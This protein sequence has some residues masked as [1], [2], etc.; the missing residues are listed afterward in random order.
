MTGHARLI[1]IVTILVGSFL[2]FLVQPL[3]ARMALPLLGGAP[4]V[5]NSAMLV[6]QALL[7]GGYA[8]AHAL[9]RLSLRRQAV[10]HLG[11][12]ALAGLTLP[13]ALADLPSPAPGW[14][15]VWVPALFLATVGPV[16]FVVSAQAPLMQRWFAADDGAGDPY[17][18]YSASNIGSFAGLVSYPF[19][20]E[21]YL[22]IAGQTRLWATGY[23]VLVVLVVLAVSARWNSAST[24]K[25]AA[26]AEEEVAAGGAASPGAGRIL[27]W[28]ALAAV[29]SGLMLST[30]THLTTDIV[31]M[32]LLWVVP[33]G[34]YLLSFSFAF[35][36]RSEFA[37]A[38]ARLAPLALLLAGSI[39]M[40]SGGHASLGLL[41]GSLALLLILATALHRRLYELRPDASRL[42]LFYLVMSAGGALGGLFTALI[43]PIAFDWVWEHPLLLL[44]AAALLPLPTLVGWRAK[45]RVSPKAGLAAILAL[46]AALA[47]AM[48]FAS[49]S[50]NHPVLIATTFGLAL[51]GVLALPSRWA[52]LAIFAALL[53]A[54]GG[55]QTIDTSLAGVRER[56]YFGIYTRDDDPTAQTRS[57]L[58]GTTVHGLQFTDPQQRRAPTTYYGP[59]SGVGLALTS[60]PA[61]GSPLRI[62]AV[63]LGTGTLA[64]YA[65][66]GQAWT[67]FEIDPVVA[68]YS[69]DGTF[70]FIS[71]CT[72]DADILIGD[73]RLVLEKVPAGAFDVLV[74]DAFSSDSIPLHLVTRE[75]LDI[76]SRTL[77]DDGLLLFH[78]SNRFIDLRPALAAHAAERGWPAMVRLDAGSPARSVNGSIWV[79]MARD[80]ARLDAVAA[81][82]PDSPW[83][84]LPAPAGKVWTD[85]HATILPYI[86][87]ERMA[88][89]M[90][91]SP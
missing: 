86:M 55:W 49:A 65:R 30:T 3:V 41:F 59:R 15:A 29:P 82:H 14:E 81:A 69:R 75:A 11:L 2:L 70:S 39:A 45:G 26:I 18:L 34:L 56:S 47:A 90:P 85:D 58:H 24:G 25:G 53:V 51:C 52:L 77:A 76:Y 36:D 87:W 73:A 31:A 1:F 64:C 63:G 48:Y 61:G 16:F 6:Y 19:L 88:G 67:F 10:V 79:V 9:S 28:L 91:S 78:I 32:P 50:E 8:Y 12:L 54:R 33:L 13:I 20:L 46:A 80:Q 83:S 5:W 35:A 66:P 84:P 7:L 40:V 57:L 89:T 71:D 23:A 38:C 68:R 72:P 4:A 62:G 17:W 42:T 21:P 60:L 22:P 74:I 43:A 27:T 37:S 44:A